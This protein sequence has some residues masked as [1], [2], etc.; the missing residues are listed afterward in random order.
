[1]SITL[2]LQWLFLTTAEM[3]SL[4]RL[5]QSKFNKGIN[6]R[7]TVDLRHEKLQIKY[8]K[9]NHV[10]MCCVFIMKTNIANTAK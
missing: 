1:M 4:C 7:R 2:Y 8:S 5:T 9:R 6:T 3:R 10:T